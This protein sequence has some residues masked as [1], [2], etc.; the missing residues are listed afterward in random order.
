MPYGIFF[1]ALSG[2]GFVA[3]KNFFEKFAKGVDFLCFMCYNLC[4]TRRKENLYARSKR[5]K[6]FAYQY[7][8]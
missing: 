6:G 1:F 4:S 2:I 8:I 7:G 3:Y 5:L